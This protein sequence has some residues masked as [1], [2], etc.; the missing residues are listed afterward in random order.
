MSEIEPAL[1]A[2]LITDAERCV[3]CA[4]CLPYCPTYGLTHEEGDSPRGR[5]ALIQALAEGSL[6]PSSV[7][8][9]HLEGCLS[10]RAC[11][12]VCPAGVPYG[13][14]L[15][16]AR[17]ELKIR[18]RESRASQWLRT[19]VRF[20]RLLAALLR[21][22]RPFARL[23]I[24]LPGRSLLAHVRSTRLHLADG[25]RDGE[26]VQLFLG[27]IARALDADTL[28]ASSVLLARA[29]YRVQ[30]P[31]T[32]GCCGA[33]AQHAGER[34]TAAWHARRN[35]DAFGG[36]AP[37][38]CAASGCTAQL[39]EY[40]PLLGD[41][42]HF[43]DRVRSVAELL[44]RAIESGRLYPVDGLPRVRV[45]LHVPCTQRN[46]L[47]SEASRWCLESLPGVEIITL[48]AACCGAAGSHCLDRPTTAARLRV[49]LLD[50]VRDSH[51]DVIV[52]TNIGCRLQLADGIE[53]GPE[54]VHLA[55]FLEPRLSACRP[56][57]H[58]VGK[59]SAC[60]H[61]GH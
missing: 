35:A 57:R 26:H 12:A 21:L 53:N 39:I 36:N 38:A 49:P 27:C 25:P 41:E 9:A 52:T 13:R 17:A 10:C 22:A 31:S 37:I 14:L 32:Q 28:S 60:D 50:A 44:S 59:R 24:P 4:L 54:V 2:H 7:A 29:G 11:E 15:D 47:R 5:I 30:T 3:K 55:R 43:A 23:P 6:E 45:A 16:N 42:G 18:G 33:L 46:V 34:G 48:P 19:L 61:K 56:R 20:P 40:G 1:F 58:G 51:A 8:R